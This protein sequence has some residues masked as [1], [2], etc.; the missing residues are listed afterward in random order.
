MVRVEQKFIR[1]SHLDALLSKCPQQKLTQ[2]SIFVKM[3]FTLQIN[4]LYEKPTSKTI[5]T[6]GSHSV[7]LKC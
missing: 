2:S 7:I 6:L 5:V 1:L 3:T 4:H